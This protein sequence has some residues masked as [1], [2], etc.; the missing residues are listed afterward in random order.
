MHHTCAGTHYVFHVTVYGAPPH[1]LPF[2]PFLTTVT[3]LSLH[4]THPHPPPHTVLP[5]ILPISPPSLVLV[6]HN[7]LTYVKS[8]LNK[9][10]PFSNNAPVPPS[11]CDNIHTD[12]SILCNICEGKLYPPYTERRRTRTGR[13][14]G[15]KNALRE[16]KAW[17]KAWRCA[18]GMAFNTAKF[19]VGAQLRSTLRKVSTPPWLYPGRSR[20]DF[21]S[22]LGA[23]KDLRCGAMG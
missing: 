2:F 6:Y 16:G 12:I 22:A 4:V 23:S 18:Q 17:P 1:Y 14:W 10:P 8:L 19:H 3:T 7:H 9:S 11:H 15:D 13:A 21:E 5:S 20:L